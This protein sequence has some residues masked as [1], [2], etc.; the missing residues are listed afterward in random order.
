MAF[1][2]HGRFGNL[3]AL[4]AGTTLA[5]A[6]NAAMF[7]WAE[8]AP[9]RYVSASATGTGNGG[10]LAPWT[11]AQAATNA[12]AGDVVMFLAGSGGAYVLTSHVG[13]SGNDRFIGAFRPAN[14]GAPGNPIVFRTEYYAA[15]L[16]D[17]SPNRTV[18]SHDG[19]YGCPTLSSEGRSY[20]T[21]RGFFVNEAT[22]RPDGDEGTLCLT[23]GTGCRAEYNRLIGTNTNYGTNHPGVRLERQVSGAVVDN[24]ISNYGPTV[25]ENS[26][27]IMVYSS[28]SYELA[29]NEIFGC[30]TGLFLKGDSGGVRIYNPASVH[31]NNVHNCTFPLNTGGP[32]APQNQTYTLDVYQNIFWSSNSNGAAW[33]LHVYDTISPTYI[34]PFNNVFAGNSGLQ[35]LLYSTGGSG[36]AFTG[37]VFRNNIWYNLGSYALVNA[38]PISETLFYRCDFDHSCWY[39]T[40]TTVVITSTGNKTLTQFQADGKGANDIKTN[41]LFQPGSFKLQTTALG[42][43]SNSPCL[44]RGVDE[45]QLLGGATS[46][47]INYGCYILPDQSDVIGV[48]AA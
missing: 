12:V 37:F 15:L 45:M 24:K 31:H 18:L 43:A 48:R 21:F 5:L 9:N 4:A 13:G 32:K 22:A 25:G 3:N 47:P 23:N 40:G 29:H 33:L 1:R 30:S 44:S 7:L 11:P 6:I 14:S 36:D 35:G 10:Y 19:A 34:R 16:A 2:V 26:A 27:G 42:Y 38:G 20:I 39:N 41:P 8:E 17:D 28:N 46:D